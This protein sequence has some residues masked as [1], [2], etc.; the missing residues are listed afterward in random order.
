MTLAELL[1][2]AVERGASDL[3]LGVGLP[4][5]LRVDGVLTP[6]EGRE[7]LEPSHTESLLRPI[8]APAWAKKL[9]ELGE[10]DFAYSLSGIGRFRVNAFK[11][12]GS[13]GAA[14]RVI[15]REI[16]SWQSLGLPPAIQGLVRR[17][18]GLIVVTGSAG[19]G[20]STTLAAMIDLIN[21]ERRCHIITL[22]DP[23]EYLHRH[24]KSIINQR[25]VGLD[26]SSFAAGL[27]AALRQDPDVILLGEMRDL[28]TTSTALAAAET[29]HLVMTTL[30]TNTAVQAIE[31]IIDIF[32]PYQ[33]GQIR[34]QVASTLQAVLCQQLLPRRA[35]RGR[36]AAF[37]VL[38]V[39]PAV[40][41]LIREGRT[42]QILSQMQMGAR[43]GMQTF[44]QA[45]LDLLQRGLVSAEVVAEVAATTL[46]R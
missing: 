32:P 38:L 23:I 6:L 27:R 34:V 39:T 26:T 36:V 16:P 44:E 1:A 14:I 22:E 10:V 41:M 8:L 18:Q 43:E 40:R 29:G 33:Q 4:P 46:N 19:S 20:K 7:P 17:Q 11:Q 35:G 21:E 31:R 25:E 12:R 13:L 45:Y 5:I 15:P 42:H 28:E 9:E 24:K 3:H 30:H 2:Q 37:E